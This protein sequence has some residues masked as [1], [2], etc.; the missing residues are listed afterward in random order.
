MALL[1][2]ALAPATLLQADPIPDLLDPPPAEKPTE[3]ARTNKIWNLKG[4]DILTLVNQV[5]KETGK[6][7]V[8]DPQVK[9]NVTM[10]SSHPMSADEL[11]HVFL[12]ILQIHGFAA[13]DTGYAIKIIPNKTAK[14]EGTPLDSMVSKEGNE[15]IITRVIHA[16]D[17]PASDLI[18]VL[19]PLVPK[20]GHIAVY[21]PTNDIIVTDR[22][23]NVDRITEII[24]RLDQPTSD[25]IE[26]I[27]LKYAAAADLVQTVQSMLKTK[28]KAAS[29]ITLAADER[30]NSVLVSGGKNNRLHIRALIAQLDTSTTQNGGNTQVIYLKYLRAK[31]LAPIISSLIGGEEGKSKSSSRSSRSRIPSRPTIG[32][33]DSKH[34]S[35]GTFSGYGGSGML[36][37]VNV[38]STEP[39]GGSAGP[40]VQWEETTNSI[41]ITAPPATMRNIRNVIAKLDIR[42]AQVVI[43]VIV[44]EI[45][46]TRVKDL[47]VEWNTGGSARVATRFPGSTTP[48]GVVTSIGAGFS[49]SDSSGIGFTDV[50]TMG[51]GLNFGFFPLHIRTC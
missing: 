8:V 9:G 44:V 15:E 24:D 32:S 37:T 10:I 21:Q 45:N 49:D 1:G 39:K 46:L 17:I 35:S 51:A 31:D 43:E 11:F 16:D 6:N 20:I 22:A 7:F 33:S 41:I 12:S 34:M 38:S 30:T 3:S 40:N 18:K 47:G 28:G 48:L 13:I 25:N 26:I 5:S 19:Q 36:R 42:R 23:A 14:Q 4:V 27:P 29:P 2:L 50:A